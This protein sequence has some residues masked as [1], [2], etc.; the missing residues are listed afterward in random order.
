MDIVFQ[1]NERQISGRNCIDRI[2]PQVERVS[3]E[4]GGAVAHADHT[5]FGLPASF[6]DR[7][8][9]QAQGV[10]GRKKILMLDGQS[11]REQLNRAGKDRSPTTVVVVIGGDAVVE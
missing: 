7:T 5:H 11:P 3:V 10:R 9:L 6:W 1:L 2:A 8:P 4:V